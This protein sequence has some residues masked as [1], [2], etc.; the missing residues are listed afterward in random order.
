MSKL[1]NSLYTIKI[2]EAGDTS[3]KA[4][5]VLDKTHEIFRGHFPSQPVLPGVTMVEMIKDIVHLGTDQHYSLSK[6][7]NIKFLK[8][9]DPTQS[10]KLTF[11][12][13]MQAIDDDLK[14]VAN[15]TL[16]DGEANFKFKGVFVK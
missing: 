2:I 14:V 11:E 12:L 13:T 15:S 8:V 16:S 4:E 6:G 1:L 3:I 7:D 5:V 10:D 9:V